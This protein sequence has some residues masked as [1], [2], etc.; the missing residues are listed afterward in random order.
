MTTD[1]EDAPDWVKA[2]EAP[3][4]DEHVRRMMDKLREEMNS[5]CVAQQTIFDPNHWSGSGLSVQTNHTD[6][7]MDVIEPR[8]WE[9]TVR[10]NRGNGSDTRGRLDPADA[11]RIVE[12]AIQVYQLQ[13]DAERFIQKNMAGEV[14]L[15]VRR[16]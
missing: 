8:F 2:E 12:R 1:I 14:V 11:R 5:G 15:N 16:R 13:L 3:S 7:V 9:V 10:G 6:D 4:N